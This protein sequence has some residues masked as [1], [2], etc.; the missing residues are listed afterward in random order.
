MDS[1]TVIAAAVQA[2]PVF[3]DRD[4]TV[5]KAARLIKEAAGDGARLIAFPEAF[6]PTY[7]DWVW[8]T[9][10]WADGPARWY[11]R[12]LDQAVV[13]PGPATARLGKAARAAGA[14]VS[15][16]VN[17]LDG[18]TLYNTQ[19]WLGPDGDVLGVH[20]KLMPTGGERLVW[21]YGDGSTMPVLD[22]PIGRLGGLV[23]WENYMPLARY[24]LYSQGIDIHVAPTWDNSDMWVPTMRHIAKEGRMH[25]I[26]VTFCLRGSDIPDDIP[27]RDDIYGGDDDWLARGNSCIVGPE[28]DLLAG[29]LEGSEGIVAAELDLDRARLSRRQFD[30]VGHYARPDVFRLEVNRRP[31]PATTF[32]DAPSPAVSTDL[33][34]DRDDLAI[35]EGEARRRGVPFTQVLRELVERRAAELRREQAPRFGLGRGDGTI[36]QES[37]DDADSPAGVRGSG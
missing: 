36:A 22:T 8:R 11:E 32:T 35:L 18:A 26:G 27:G 4:A 10:P 31:T 30:P 13:I 20:R 7:P 1:T 2:A 17:E 28:G 16:G 34:A 23:C 33:S 12:L 21:G 19:L 25:V 6:V 14:Y 37:G 15:V 3:L 9:T 29:P 5:D 24:S